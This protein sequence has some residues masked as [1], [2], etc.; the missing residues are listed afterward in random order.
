MRRL[1]IFALISVAALL[2]AAAP[3]AHAVIADPIRAD[4][5][6]SF[7]VA[8]TTLPPGVYTFRI[9]SPMNQQVMVVSNARG[10][11]ILM[12]L[13]TPTIDS[14]RPQHSELIFKRYGRTQYLTKIYQSGFK[15]GDSVVYPSREQVW[16]HTGHWPPTN[17][18]Q[19]GEQQ[20]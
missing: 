3:R 9:Q 19:Y 15:Q 8:N 12:F 20:G 16:L 13:V 14:H 1:S 4:I 5:H 6:H 10:S 7:V 18:G 11:K 2:V 17:T